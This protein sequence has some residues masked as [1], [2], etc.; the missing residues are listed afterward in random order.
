VLMSYSTVSG[1]YSIR[2]GKN[3]LV[4]GDIGNTSVYFE[5]VT[6]VRHLYNFH[7]GCLNS[8]AAVNGLVKCLSGDFGHL[9]GCLT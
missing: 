2:L 1:R 8:V 6:R 5:H 7:S 4:T 9:T 3:I